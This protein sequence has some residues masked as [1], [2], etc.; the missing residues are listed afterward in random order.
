[1]QNTPEI[2]KD[3]INR[4]LCPNC[5]GNMTF[6]A[7]T[8]AL[9]CPYCQY[10]QQVSTG[11]TVEERDFY[12]AL[13]S[14][15][16][17]LQ[18]MA[19]NAMQ[20][21]CGSCGAIVNFTPP[22]TATWCDF[23]GTKIVAQPKASDPL[24]APE[25]VL[26]FGVPQDAAKKSFNTWIGSRWFAPSALKNMSQTERLSSIYI[27]YWTFDAYSTSSYTGE[28]GDHYYETEYYEENGEQRSRQ[29]RHTN[30]YYRS[31]NV[32]R[33]FD[34]VTVPATTSVLPKY[35]EKLN[36]DFTDLVPY[37]PAYL[38]G[39]K[40]QTYQVTLEQGFEKFKE[41]AYNV[42]W[43][44]CRND[45]GGDEQRVNNIDINYANIT[46]KHLLV[47]VYASAYQFKGK[48]FQIVINGRTGE[49]QGE[50]PYS[51]LK[52][53]CLVVAVVSAILFILILFAAL[54]K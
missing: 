15:N 53:G 13:Q 29:V 8:Q 50:R 27:P 17:N 7:E 18:P 16:N 5:A 3:N 33:Q 9:T 26:P 25:G 49:V 24:V 12:T 41:I 37:E 44:D 42:I 43:A 36:W 20:V 47:P 11:G 52:I 34:D 51:W 1:M 38:A 14:A 19:T 31:G 22:E 23:C 30:W 6:S 2:N 28:R 54:K 39:H 21:G 35:V 48:A 32:S 46:F 45:I 10:K 40:A 4:F